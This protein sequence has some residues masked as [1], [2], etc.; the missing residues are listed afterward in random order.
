MIA[1]QAKKL[2]VHALRAFRDRLQLPLD[3]VEVERLDFYRPAE[4]S[5]EIAY[6]QKRR[7]E[8]GGYLPA[9]RRNAPPVAVPLLEAYASWA[10]AAE[11]RAMSTTVAV[12][13]LLGN[14]LKD[15][16]L[17]P[18]IVPIVADEARTFGM[19]SLFR[20]IGIY[21]PLGQLYEPEDAGSLLVYK[22][23]KDGQLLEEGITEAGALSSWTAAA[24][25]PTA[26]R[27]CDAAVLY[28]LLDVWVSAR[29]RSYLG[30]GRS[31]S[32]R[33]PH[34]RDGGE[35]HAGRRGSAA[36]GR[37]QPRPGGYRPNCRAYDPAFAYEF[38]VIFD[39]GVRGMMQEGRDEFYYITVMNESYAQ[40]SMPAGVDGRR[41]RRGLYRI[42]CTGPTAAADL[43]GCSALARS[44]CE[45][46]K[47][48]VSS[49]PTGAFLPKSG[50]SRAIPS[51]R[52]TLRRGTA[53][54]ASIPASAAD[55]PSRRLSFGDAPFV[56]ASDYV[57]AYPQLIASY[58]RAPFTALERTGLDA[59]IRATG[60]ARVFRN[61]PL[62]RRRRRARCARRARRRRTKHGRRRDRKIWG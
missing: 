36:S 14:L 13:R 58:I 29:R 59:A 48:R 54:P 23:A 15:A 3:D 33:F 47:P 2:D 21:S 30:R 17:G 12:I 8:L 19:A 51:W 9:R 52:A 38:A 25:S 57:R 4:D 42:T 46:M 32:A 60:V 20:Q 39:H 35:N 31:T 43:S 55:Q 16:V 34:R 22:E 62:E 27:L 24:T 7:A 45:A 41:H 11:G 37:K 6:L 49:K 26:P 5:A 1:H 44:C 56:A 50:A 61:R 18:R 28:F 10:L 40:P 53:Q